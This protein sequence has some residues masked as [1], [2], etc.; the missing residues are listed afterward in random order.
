MLLTG[1]SANSFILAEYGDNAFDFAHAQ[2]VNPTFF[3]HS[4]TQSTTEW[5]SVAHDQ[6]NTVFNSGTGLF[7]FTPAG[8]S[9]LTVGASSVGLLKQLDVNTV[10]NGL[11]VNFRDGLFL[12]FGSASGDYVLRLSG[13]QTPD[14]GVLGVG[15]LSNS[16]VIA[17]AADL[18]YPNAAGF[19]F[20]H[21]QQTNPTL[22]IHSRT[23]STT[24]FVGIAHNVGGAVI[25]N[26]GSVTL[27]EAGGAETVLTV[28]TATTQMTGGRLIYTVKAADSAGSPDYVVRA[29]SLN[30]GMTNSVGT[31]TCTS[32]ISAE[33]GDGSVATTGGTAKTLTYAITYVTGANTC[34]IKFNIDSD[35]GTVTSA[36]ITYTLILDGPGVVS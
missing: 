14:S 3:I 4:A 11:A 34:A 13:A 19:D 28:T 25:N 33:T 5:F 12:G 16:L 8:T 24:E 29:G 20:A 22:F 10:A 18:G 36:S 27:T 15:A 1:T 2:A 7:N 6:T 31:T 35:I 30:F 21:A 23:Q 32:A 26:Q 9:A 17:E